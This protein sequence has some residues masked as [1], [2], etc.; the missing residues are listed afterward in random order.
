MKLLKWLAMAIMLV[1]VSGLLLF[2]FFGFG[3]KRGET[4]ELPASEF[5]PESIRDLPI[6]DIRKVD[7]DFFDA[8][9]QETTRIDGFPC[10]AGNVRFTRSGQLSGCE[11]AEDAVIQD[12]LIPKNT[13]IVLNEELN[14]YFYYFP[15]D[16]E[17]QGYLT[18]SRLSWLEIPVRFYPDGRLRGFYSRSNVVVHG[19]PC[20]RLN[21]GFVLRLPRLPTDTGIALH[22]NGNVRRCTL[23]R[24]AQIAGLNIS[25]GSDIRISEDGEVTILNDSW[26]RR[27]GLWIT[28]FFD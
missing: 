23:S 25:A 26:R 27:T 16:T 17:I 6:R 8:R 12:N 20:R 1:C 2:T 10:A 18:M 9:L 28:G 24:D 3:Q 21:S 11:L 4:V 15:E 14:E 13:S 19:I 22:E 7:G 5:I